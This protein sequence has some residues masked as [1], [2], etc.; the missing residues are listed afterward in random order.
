MAA[1]PDAFA[2][3]KGYPRHSPR[4]ASVNRGLVVAQTLLA[5]EP[6]RCPPSI[7]TAA[8]PR[9]PRQFTLTMKHLEPKFPDFNY[10]ACEISATERRTGDRVMSMH[11]PSMSVYP[12]RLRPLPCRAVLQA[13]GGGDN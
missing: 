5:A 8:T 4:N 2:C 7:R 13:V 11:V 12:S 6:R 10:L 9:R 3:D 1:S